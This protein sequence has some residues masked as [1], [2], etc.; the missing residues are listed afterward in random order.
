MYTVFLQYC[1][2]GEHSEMFQPML[3]VQYY[4]AVNMAET[5]WAFTISGVLAHRDT[6]KFLGGPQ[7]HAKTS[8]VAGS[9]NL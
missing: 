6:G 2:H 8:A 4:N 3:A 5:S 9:G 7:S 1:M